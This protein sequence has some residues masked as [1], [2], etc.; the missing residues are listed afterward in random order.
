MRLDERV[1]VQLAGGCHEPGGRPV[2]EIAEQQ[3][4][5]VCSELLEL[6]DLVRVV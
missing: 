2:V 6:H 3:Q 4:D 5:G 1:H